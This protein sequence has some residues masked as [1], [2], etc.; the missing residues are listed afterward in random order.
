MNYS[1]VQCRHVIRGNDS[2]GWRLPEIH[3]IHMYGIIFKTTDRIPGKSRCHQKAPSRIVRSD[4]VWKHRRQ[5]NTNP[6][7]SFTEGSASFEETRTWTERRWFGIIRANVKVNVLHVRRFSIIGLE[8]WCPGLDDMPN[9]CSKNVFLIHFFLGQPFL[10]TGADSSLTR[11]GKPHKNIHVPGS[12][13]NGN[14][15]QSRN[16]FQGAAYKA[17]APN[18]PPNKGTKEMPRFLTIRLMQRNAQFPMMKTMPATPKKP[19]TK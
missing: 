5:A 7:G 11:Y 13:T 14:Q 10:R 1:P 6:V 8:R 4:E 17:I 12:I 18:N 2:A 9:L 15:A 19:N 3:E 16:I